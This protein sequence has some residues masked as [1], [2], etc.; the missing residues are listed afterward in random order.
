MVFCMIQLKCVATMVRRRNTQAHTHH[1]N[2][3]LPSIIHTFLC[4]LIM[5]SAQ[6]AQK[7]LH[8]LTL[9]HRCHHFIHSLS[10]YFVRYFLIVN[11]IP[12]VLVISIILIITVVRV[13]KQRTQ[14]T[15][16]PK[17]KKRKYHDTHF[18]IGTVRCKTHYSTCCA[19]NITTSVTRIIK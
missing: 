19:N 18:N 10:L 5:A 3:P 13:C 4:F 8:L 12:R 15:S 14:C 9:L 6:G 7:S 2:P 11:S 16:E 1:G 17:K